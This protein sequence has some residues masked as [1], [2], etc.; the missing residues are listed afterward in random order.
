MKK[1]YSASFKTQIV[2]EIL[3]EEKTLSQIAAEHGI[4]PMQLSKWKSM[5]LKALPGVFGAERKKA[6]EEK[7]AYEKK[8]EQLYAEIGRLTT[9]LAWLKKKSGIEFE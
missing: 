2:Q 7:A 8:L 9:Q 3:K 5:A 6:G 4:H 1:Q